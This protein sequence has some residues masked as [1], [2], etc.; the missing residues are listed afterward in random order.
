MPGTQQLRQQERR[1]QKLR[2][3]RD[4]VAEG[5]LVIRQMTPEERA[6]YLTGSGETVAHRGKRRR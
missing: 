5:K 4:Q 6:R 2:D 1:E 3:I